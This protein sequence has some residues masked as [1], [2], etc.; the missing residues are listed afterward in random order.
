MG[1][2]RQA[3][4]T[5]MSV[6]QSARRLLLPGCMPVRQVVRVKAMSRRRWGEN[7]AILFSNGADAMLCGHTSCR[8]GDDACC[9]GKGCVG[10][11]V[12][13]A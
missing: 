13:V 6:V 1:Y 11:R 7:E 9:L 4:F 8:D 5:S 3:E 12:V 2:L 10:G